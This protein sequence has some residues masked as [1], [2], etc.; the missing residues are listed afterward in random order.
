M[1]P[2]LLDPLFYAVAVPAVILAGLSKGGLGG[3]MGFVGVPLMALAMSPLQAAAILLPILIVMDMV[4][5]WI[6]RGYF[7]R[8]LLLA[9]LPG[10][11]VGI[12]IG[13]AAASVVT[14]DMV[15]M[16]VGLIALLFVGRWALDWL[17]GT[18]PRAARPNRAAGGLWGIVAATP[19]SWPT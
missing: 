9:T 6:W 3:A 15:R 11:M 17:V 14:P 4:G 1:P 12:G 13:W 7:D 16:M 19:P 8:A 2:L 10:A 18:P 5:L